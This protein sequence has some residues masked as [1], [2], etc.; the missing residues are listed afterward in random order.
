[1]EFL[2]LPEGYS[3]GDAAKVHNHSFITKDGA[4]ENLQQGGVLTVE[5]RA[6]KIPLKRVFF[7][8]NIDG[9]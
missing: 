6:E 9:I 8:C 1:M 7:N 4:L 3:F 5:Y 2:G